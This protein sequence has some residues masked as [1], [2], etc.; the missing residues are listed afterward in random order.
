MFHSHAYKGK[1]EL[2]V[3]LLIIAVAIFFRFY[4]IDVIPPGLWVDEAMNGT[5]AL[6]VVDDRDP[7]IFYPDNNGR[8]GLFISIQG[9]SVWAFGN[10]AWALRVVAGLFGVLT[11]AGLYILTKELFSSWHI[12]AISAFL[13][14]TSFWHVNFSRISFRAIMLPFI[15]VWAV[16][17]LWKGIKK[18]HFSDFIA[19]GIFAG[20]GFYTYLSYRVAPLIFLAIFINYW[21]FIRSHYQ[22]T[23]YNYA[24][25][26]LL[27]GFIVFALVAFVVA[28][29]IILYFYSHL[30][31]AAMR[32]SQLSVFNY[33]NPVKEL[34]TSI[35]RTLGM[36]NF[37][38]DGNQRHNI[39]GDPMLV[40][41][42]GVFFIIGFIREL[43][44]WFKMPHGHP[45]PVHTLLFAWFFIMLLPGFLSTESPH[46]LRTIGVIPVVMIFAAKGIWWLLEVISDWHGLHEANYATNKASYRH[47]AISI[48]K[49][50]IVVL[51]I[52]VAIVEYN[53]YFL[54]WGKSEFTELAFTKNLT[55]ISY[56]LENN[57][58]TS[59]TFIVVNEPGVVVEGVSIFAQPI[60][61][62]TRTHTS[63]AQQEKQVFYI[64][65]E[66][67]NDL[68]SVAHYRM[69][70]LLETQRVK[71]F[72]NTNTRLQKTSYENFTVYSK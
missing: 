63:N 27:K 54:I 10:E 60:K 21:F 69:I 7:K 70:P 39:S 15:I 33:P 66:Q 4:Q 1:T 28:M 26:R 25:D 36:F 34:F 18:S 43:I 9:L 42:I 29:P 61:F 24:R 38:G 46:A 53:R 16:Y 30:G 47:E 5:D 51:L 6:H 58:I 8:E 13:L 65:E 32:Q 72:I 56:Y 45:S 44:A 17:F 41:P 35:I 31:D 55:D 23:E 19:A 12:G 57:S 64:S 67:V 62:L 14:A 49:M 37:Y 20:L 52:A 50:V 48:K 2:W 71:N 22:Y 40:W 3:F 68:R 59:P 11:V